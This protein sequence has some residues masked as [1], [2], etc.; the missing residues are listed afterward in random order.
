MS[1]NPIKFWQALGQGNWKS[2]CPVFSRMDE[3]DAVTPDSPPLPNPEWDVM[4]PAVLGFAAV[5]TLGTL[6]VGKGIY[7][8]LIGLG[9]QSEEIFRGDQLPFLK[10]PRSDA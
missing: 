7:Q 1:A 9:K 6:G 5:L 3:V 8:T 4:M 2:H 10:F